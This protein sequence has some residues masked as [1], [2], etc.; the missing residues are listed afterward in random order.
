MLAV[1][2]PSASCNEG[3]SVGERHGTGSSYSASVGRDDGRLSTGRLAAAW[4]A[5]AEVQL[6]EPEVRLDFGRLEVLHQATDA[7][8]FVETFTATVSRPPHDLFALDIRVVHRAD[9]PSYHATLSRHTEGTR[10]DPI[11]EV[12]AGMR[13]GLPD[14]DTAEIFAQLR[15]SSIGL[16]GAPEREFIRIGHRYWKR[17]PDG[18]TG[19][20]VPSRYPDLPDPTPV[21]RLSLAVDAFLPPGRRPDPRG[22]EAMHGR[23]ATHYRIEGEELLRDLW[24]GLNLELPVVRSAEGSLD[25][26][27]QDDGLILQ[28]EL[29]LKDADGDE[30]HA[31]LETGDFGE[32]AAIMPPP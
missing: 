10:F 25:L 11:E 12:I 26:W 31:V 30:Y 2:L 13:D 3:A 7:P 5:A 21:G 29:R 19:P 6:P 16:Y 1:A 8:G 23:R 20:G 27:M 28:A 14:G 18:W 9:P 4:A 17:E 24:N 32:Q 15:S 22:E